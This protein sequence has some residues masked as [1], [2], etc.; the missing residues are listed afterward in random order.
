MHC[1]ALNGSDARAY[2]VALVVAL[3]FLFLEGAAA[4]AVVAETSGTSVQWRQQV[5][6]LLRRLNKPHLASFEVHIY[7]DTI[8]WL[9]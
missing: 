8:A 5:H 3:A 4:A 9:L 7:V 1:T 6:S 2:L